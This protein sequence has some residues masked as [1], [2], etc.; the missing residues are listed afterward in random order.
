ME[1]LEDMALTQDMEDRHE[2]NFFLLGGNIA[3]HKE[4]RGQRQ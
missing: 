1:E 4:A 2:R 3:G